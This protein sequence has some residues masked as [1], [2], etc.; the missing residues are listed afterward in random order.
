[1]AQMKCPKCGYTYDNSPKY[2]DLEKE[3]SVCPFCAVRDS[4]R[5]KSKTSISSIVV[6]FV[7]IA[8]LVGLAVLCIGFLPNLFAIILLLFDLLLLCGTAYALYSSWKESSL[9]RKNPEEYVRYIEKQEQKIKEAQERSQ[10]EQIKRDAIREEELSKLPVCPICGK[11]DNVKRLSSFNRSASI[12]VKGLASAKI[13][14]QYEC[15]YC[16]H[17]W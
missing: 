13:G 9:L 10:K 14:K 1:M 7:V 16:K 6:G 5:F 17:L 2:Y 11:K 8:A 3:T 12:A 15:T 4:P